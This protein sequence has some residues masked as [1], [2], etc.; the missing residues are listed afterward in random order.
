MQRD[1]V[2]SIE[3]CFS[4]IR[5]NAGCLYNESVTDVSCIWSYVA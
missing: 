5:I 2:A 4:F 1:C 3:I